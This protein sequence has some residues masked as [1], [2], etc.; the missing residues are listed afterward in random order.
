MVEDSWWGLGIQSARPH[1]WEEVASGQEPKFSGGHSV[2]LYFLVG[3]KHT[4]G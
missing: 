3:F 2:L 4:V 1:E